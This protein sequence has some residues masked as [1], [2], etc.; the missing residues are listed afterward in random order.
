MFYRLLVQNKKEPAYYGELVWPKDADKVLMR[1]KTGD[2]EY[3]V[4]YGN[5]TA[6]TVSVEKLA[7]LESQI[8]Q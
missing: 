1:W 5:L 7:E 6:E 8:E 3:R 2:N 4:I